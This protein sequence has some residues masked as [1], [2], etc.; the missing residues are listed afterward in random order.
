[1]SLILMTTLFYKALILQGEI[2]P[3]SLLG[4]KALICLDAIKFVLLSFFTLVDKIQLKI[5]AK[6]MLRNVKSPLLIRLYTVPYFFVRSLRYTAS[7]RHGY[8]DFKM[9]ITKLASNV[10]IVGD[11]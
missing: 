2:S 11:K 1:M 9:Y 4:L 6:S 3:W 8:L 5:L 7:Y 10:F